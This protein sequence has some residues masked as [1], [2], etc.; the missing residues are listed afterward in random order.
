MGCGHAF[1]LAC[2]R[3]GRAITLWRLAVPDGIRTRVTDVKAHV[4]WR[5]MAYRIVSLYI[6]FVVIRSDGR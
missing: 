1:T 2:S 4:A 3:A 5:A 6:T